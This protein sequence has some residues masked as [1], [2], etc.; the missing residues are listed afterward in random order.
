M[1]NLRRTLPELTGNH[2]SNPATRGVVD[3]GGLDGDLFD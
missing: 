3:V 2:G 1:S